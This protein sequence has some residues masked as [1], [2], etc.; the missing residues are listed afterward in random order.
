VARHSSLKIKADRARE[1]PDL[2]R[3]DKVNHVS[4]ATGRVLAKVGKW[5]W[6][7]LLP[8]GKM[9]QSEVNLFYLQ[10]SLCPW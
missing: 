4:V 9:D 2:P 10:L 6:V 7:N 5:E 1:I 8:G 3:T